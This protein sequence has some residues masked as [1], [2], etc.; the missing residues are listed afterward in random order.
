M[1]WL[2][3]LLFSV[4][5]GD[6]LASTRPRLRLLG[7]A[8]AVIATTA[9]WGLA[10]LDTLP[11]AVALGVIAVATCLWTLSTPTAERS[12][13]RARRTLA[14]LAIPA[15]LAVAFSGFASPVGG[16]LASWIAWLAVPALGDRP[17]GQVLMLAAV[18]LANLATG[19]RIVRLALVA[20]GARPPR[21]TAEP[22]QGPASEALS[23]GRLLGPMER[24]LV[25]GF[26]ATGHVEA[27]AVVVAA[28]GLLRFPE[29]QAAARQEPRA[30]D[31]VTEYFLVGTFS[32]LLLAL[33]SVV[34][35]A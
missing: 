11:D 30:V 19:N 7:T 21:L 25:I 2:A 9:A 10:G 29:L 32:S 20:V 24:L 16:P 28:K 17:A 4:G 8:A 31:E 23:G 12:P 27:A 34:L 5:L 15:G 22:G 13:L 26:G 35:L 33:G 3:L 14:A 1:S 6:L 18:V